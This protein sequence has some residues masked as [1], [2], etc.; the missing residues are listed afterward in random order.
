[1]ITV[2][3]G[4]T[5]VHPILWMDYASTRA[6][7]TRTHDLMSGSSAITLAPA[8]PRRV[9]L[10]FLFHDEDHSKACEDLHATAGVLTVTDPD[11]A[12]HSMQYVVI[13]SVSRDLDTDTARN[14]IVT[15]EV[16]EVGAG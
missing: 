9:K 8:G 6:A 13:G 16:Q 7:N 12:T 14:W 15:A 1:M 4:T 11:R 2:T 5:T 10:A 3:D